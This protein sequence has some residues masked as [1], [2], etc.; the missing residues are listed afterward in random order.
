MTLLVS[1]GNSAIRAAFR[2]IIRSILADTKALYLKP[3]G[4]LLI[5]VKAEPNPDTSQE[6]NNHDKEEQRF[7][8]TEDIIERYLVDDAHE[9]RLQLNDPC[10]KLVEKPGYLEKAQDFEVVSDGV[11]LALQ[12]QDR[13]DAGEEVG[14]EEGGQVVRGDLLEADHED[15]FFVVTGDEGEAD[16]DHHHQVD[17]QLEVPERLPIQGFQSERYH[18][19]HQEE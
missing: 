17:E 4:L 8:E 1:E 16:V 7:R 6:V 15:D 11:A 12:D 5:I 13:G 19:W 2:Q 18:Q 10:G 14:H 9:E 3:R